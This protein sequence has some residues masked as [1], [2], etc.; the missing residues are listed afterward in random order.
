VVK[1]YL[2]TSFF[3]LCVTKRDAPKMLV[4][5]QTSLEWWRTQ[6]R[7]FELFIS[8]EVV[9]ELSS[10]D[11]VN[12]DEALAMIEGLSILDPA[13][14]VDGFAELLVSERVMPAP[15]TT[16][17]ALHVAYAAV[18]GIE[19]IL[20]WN[21]AHLANPNKKT[22]LAVI[23]ARANLIAPSVV[24]PDMLQQEESP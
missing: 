10:P 2:E 16:G 15:A 20:S 24:T 7:L 23:C 19:Y 6:A 8:P 3:S 1:A 5:K 14:E 4:W 13:P 11:F 21:V 18:Y 12:R 22:H 17:D 9:R